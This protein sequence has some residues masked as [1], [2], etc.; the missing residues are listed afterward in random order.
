MSLQQCLFVQELA[1]IEGGERGRSAVGCKCA[2]SARFQCACRIKSDAAGACSLDGAEEALAATEN[3]LAAAT[4][5][6]VVQIAQ[7]QT[8]VAIDRW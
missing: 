3:G 4:V 8:C 5:A 2:G 7:Q 6:N 1:A